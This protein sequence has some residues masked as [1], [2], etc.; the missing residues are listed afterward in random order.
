LTIDVLAND[1]DVDIGDTRTVI[2]VSA[3][4]LQGTISV[5][6]G[7]TSVIYSVGNAFQQLRSGAIAT[8]VFSYTIADASGVQSTA[9]V[10]VAI[11]G[12]NDSPVATD[13]VFT[14]NEDAA[15]T[16]IAV[17]SND[18][19]PDV[20]DTKR[21]LSV[22]TTGILG[23]VSI[24]TNGASISYSPGTAFQYLLAGQTATE[25][26]TY[27]MVDGAGAQSTANVTVI[28]TG[29]T[30]GPKAV[31][32]V[33]VAAEDGAPIVIDVLANDFSDLESRDNLT[34]AGIDG[35]GQFAFMELILIYGVGVGSFHPGF[36]RLLGD[37]STG[38]DG[39]SIL[40]TPLQSLNAGEVGTDLFKYTVTGSTGGQSVGTVTVTVTG[41]NDAPTAVPDHVTLGS[42]SR[43]LTIPVL[44]NDTDPDTRIDP[45][46]PATGELGPWDA[47][48][49]DSPDTKSIVSVN[50]TGLQG[51][52]AIS[53]AGLVYTVGG[54]LLTLPYGAFAQETFTYT[55]QDAA[56]AQST[57]TVSVTVTGEN[58]VPSAL[59]DT[60]ATNEDGPPLQID[61]LANDTD[62]DIPFGDSLSIASIQTT[63][64]QGSVVVSSDGR[65]LQYS[66]GSSYQHLKAGDTAFES[67]SYTIVDNQ[68]ALSTAWITVNI[69]GRNDAPIATANSLSLSE[70]AAPTTIAVLANDS[71]VDLN[72][73]KTIVSVNGSSL[74][75]A[76]TIASGGAAVV[77]T[78]GQSFQAL[79]NGQ[80]ATETFTYT[81]VDSA[82]GQSTASVTVTI[83]GANEP[84][85]IVNPPLPSAGAIVGTSG[86]DI[87]IT[88]ELADII[89][90]EAG[91]D[92]ISSGGGADTIFGGSG[93]DT[94]NGGNGNDIISGGTDRDDLTGGAGADIFRYYLAS[95]S[96]VAAFD[97]IRDFNAADGDRIDLNLIDA[98]T[99]VGGNNAFVV[100]ASFTGIA[101]QLVIVSMGS[102]LYHV[103]GDTNGDGIADLQI[104]VKSKSA[105]TGT[106]LLL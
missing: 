23:T 40:Y 70:D 67:F 4:T 59:G 103:R 98:N 44:A 63:G 81:M 66:I 69:T 5:A 37:A 65:S 45:V 16:S 93:R 31:N 102:D 43:P 32:D 91:D 64:I 60:A 100:S 106:S 85:V 56:G 7:G 95:E 46:I 34:I 48:P 21:V 51:S 99:L 54:S 104:E 75:G 72:D 71:D 38:I 14:V 35:T 92:E 84:V 41:A 13:N 10:T 53:G 105:I 62:A 94:I 89:Y 74:Q 73:T 96:T 77:Y 80:T 88:A 76:V 68:G 57:T 25:S 19:D 12:V 52:V 17:L 50:T 42:A 20:G 15:A 8:E 58:H 30:D 27:T 97:R 78:V 61:V 49:V 9:N 79:N 82:G 6:P 83:V 1:S 87:M 2:A 101:G 18:T 26:F 47:T 22:N 24:P 36:P 55:M 11:T 3:T 90:G 39:R 33:A 28:V 29:I 86:D